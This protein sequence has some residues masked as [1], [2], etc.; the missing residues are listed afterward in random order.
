MTGPTEHRPV[1]EILPGDTLLL[2]S[3]REVT[4]DRVDRTDTD[5]AGPVYSVRWKAGTLHGSLIPKR[6]GETWPARPRP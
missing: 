4:V 1:E 3:G 6:P 5:L 2:P